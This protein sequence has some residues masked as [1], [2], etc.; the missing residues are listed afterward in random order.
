MNHMR[1]M[2]SSFHM[3]ADKLNNC[4]F[5]SRKIYLDSWPSIVQSHVAKELLVY[6]INI[7]SYSLSY[8]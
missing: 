1:S 6:K 4:S 7:G 2:K 8:K 3:E 5:K